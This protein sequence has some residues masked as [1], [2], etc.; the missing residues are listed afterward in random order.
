MSIMSQEAHFTP[1]DTI[2]PAAA[3]VR[4]RESNLELFRIV[5]MLLIIAHHYVYHSGLLDIMAK[6]AVG[7][8]TLFYYAFGMWGKTGINCFVLITGYFMCRSR[9]TARKWL[10][11]AGVVVFY[12]I[13]FHGGSVFLGRYELSARYV[14]ETF[15][16]VTYVGHG[17]VGAFLVFYLFI[18]YLNILLRTM[19]KREHQLLL[20]LLLLVFIGIGK[21]PL[22]ELGWSYVPWFATLYL[23]AAYIRFYEIKP[24]WGARRWAICTVVTAVAAWMTVVAIGIANHNGR[25]L[26][27]DP[28]T[29]V[30]DCNAPFALIVSV[31]AFQTFRLMRLRYIPWVNI[32]GACTFG[33]L[34]IHDR[35]GLYPLIWGRVLN[36]AGGWG[37]PHYVPHALVSV[38]G[39]FMVCALIDRL[40][41]LV[42]E[43]TYMRLVTRGISLALRVR[44]RGTRRHSR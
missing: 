40:R 3:G 18:P 16:P 34:L 36:V 17:F 4:H 21:N 37:A 11:L 26:G 20:A 9:I 43:P 5:L 10:K 42:I 22:M 1:P 7:G 39:I 8:Q 14:F 33:V 19:S 44:S 35:T 28:F 15:S 41:Q 32:A 25:L 12:N 6:E 2:S 30:F 38:I 23:T 24:E 29:F 27:Y 13:V 31:A